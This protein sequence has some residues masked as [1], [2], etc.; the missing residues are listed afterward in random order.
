M[1]GDDSAKVRNNGDGAMKALEFTLADFDEADRFAAL[2][3]ALDRAVLAKRMGMQYSGTRDLYQEFGYVSDISFSDYQSRYER[4]GLS[5]R[6][7]DK[8]ALD[9]WAKEP[10]IRENDG[11]DDT[12]FIQGFYQLADR[13][14]L[15]KHL[16][17]IDRLA[18]LGEYAVMLIGVKGTAQLSEELIRTQG[19]E[20][21]IYLRSFDQNEALIKSVDRDPASSR[22]GLPI[23]YELDMGEIDGSPLPKEIAHWS[24]VLHVAEDA[25]DG[26]YGRPRLR[27]SYNRLFDIDKVIGS[28]AEAFW[29]LILK[30][31]V[32]TNQPGFKIDESSSALEDKFLQ[33]VHHLKRVLVLSGA[34]VD[35]LGT[36]EEPD[37]SGIFKVLIS[38]IAADIDMP[39][40][41]LIGS[42]QGIRA[43]DVDA[44]T[45]ARSI[46]A[47]QLKYA[48][49]VILRPFID[50]CISNKV[51]EA[52]KSGQY[53]IEW[54][55]LYTMTDIEEIEVS[56][57]KADTISKLSSSGALEFGLVS[58]DEAREWVMLAPDA[59]GESIDDLL[60][61]EDAMPEEMSDDA[62]AE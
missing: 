48:E 54:P 41:I 15:W 30:G 36:S 37:P 5:S 46:Q 10:E 18:G 3:D 27:R 53:E 17:D 4:D 61:I 39:Q 11:A 2:S 32:V 14:R 57:K 6:I 50:W 22:F 8:P 29:R 35:E 44:Q 38:M 19:I 59:F 49:P 51:I 43:S 45:W 47:R 26:I 23:L 31:L 25:R 34:Q 12:K 9:T 55:P 13:L 40:N 56:S 21:I 58:R 42:E 33:Y 28:S 20:D 16:T 62:T 52:P 1:D 24:R 60:D 7:V